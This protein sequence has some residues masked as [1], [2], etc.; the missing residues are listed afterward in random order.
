MEWKPGASQMVNVAGAALEIRVWGPPPDAS[1]TLVLLH[2]GLGSVSLWRDIP[3]TLALMTG[4]GV[5]AYSRAGYGQSDPVILPRQ[6][7]YMTREALDVLPH[8][9]AVAGL[10]KIILI[11]HSDGASIAAIYA[12]TIVD[13][14]LQGICLIAPHF[15]VETGGRDEILAAKNAF[16]TYDLRIRMARHHKNPENAFFGWADAWL[17]PDFMAWNIEAVI[18]GIKV[19]VL[20]IQGVS[21]QYGTMAQIDRLERGVKG[22]F[23]RLDL[24]D[25]K[26]A[27]QFEQR[28]RTLAA[29]SNFVMQPTR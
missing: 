11:G 27:P 2:E 5:L 3:E 18:S 1:P 23:A 26:H 28:V 6:I 14:R 17:N 4:C 22:P 24:A 19:P 10:Q 21:D 8:V 12:G 7:D 25:C 9:L 15:F 13:T 16:E 20:A 29:I